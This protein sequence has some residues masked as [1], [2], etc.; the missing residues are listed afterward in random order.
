MPLRYVHVPKIHSDAWYA[1]I[2]LRYVQV[3]R[4]FER[5]DFLSRRV[6]PFSPF[7]L[8][9]DAEDRR[10]GNSFRSVCFCSFSRRRGLCFGGAA[11]SMAEDLVLDT[12]IRDWVLV[13]L[14]VVMVLIGVLRYFVSKLMRSHQ[15]PDLKVVKEGSVSSFFA[16]ITI[17]QVI[18][19]ARNL[20]AAAGFIPAKS[21]RSRKTYFT[22]ETLT[23]AW[24]NFFFSGFVAGMLYFIT[25]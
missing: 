15:A 11:A 1:L 25:A 24:V 10:G 16:R 5:P 21:F 4:T 9:E 2:T 6:L 19:R 20:R 14:S 22:N 3:I 7:S 18:L 13:P 23:F 17:T 12:A 8:F